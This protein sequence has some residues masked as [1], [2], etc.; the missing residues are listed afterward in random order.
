M[1]A[2][3]FFR[4]LGDPRIIDAK[5]R[6]Q[7]ADSL[8]YIVSAAETYLEID[9]AQFVASVERIRRTRQDPGVFAR[10]FDLVFAINQNKFADASALLTELI[11]RTSQTTSFAIVPYSREELGSDYDRF[12]GLLFAELAD[13]NPMEPPSQS[14]ATA[15]AQMLREAIAIILRVDSGIHDEIEAL[16]TRIYLAVGDKSAKRFGGVTSLM[17]WGA[18]F[19]NVEVY[20]SRWD[21]VQF[22]VHEVTHALLLGLACDQPLVENSPDESYQSPLRHDPRPMDG[23]FHATLVCARLARSTELG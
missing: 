13:I 23:I 12:S 3:G 7:L 6:A 5:V 17:V 16:L 15:S 11:E 9:Q 18:T 20:R 22:L 14:Q 10:Y 21:A 1:A 19:I 2:V 4:D 8:T